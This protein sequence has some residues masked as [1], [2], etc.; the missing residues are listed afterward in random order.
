M[1]GTIS[2]KRWQAVVM[3]IYVAVSYIYI[4]VS[5]SSSF[6]FQDVDVCVSDFFCFFYDVKYNIF[7]IYE[8]TFYCI[9]TIYL[10]KRKMLVNHI[11]QY[12]STSRLWHKIVLMVFKTALLICTI[13]LLILI[14]VASLKNSTYL[15]N[16][17]DENSFARKMVMDGN[18]IVIDT[19]TVIV[20][21]VVLDFLRL[22]A[23]GVVIAILY[24]TTRKSIVCF[25]CV[26]IDIILCITGKNGI[27]YN[28]ILN[29]RLVYLG[30]I[31]L[32]EKVW[33]AVLFNVLLYIF[34]VICFKRYRKDML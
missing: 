10:I 15:C 3:G 4:I 28:S 2:A 20:T 32:F 25:L 13:N 6:F 34:G 23:T 33:N 14:I 16:W 27:Y 17:S 24:W 30:I 21:Y 8:L 26:F 7:L 5:V 11:V 31:D 22:V 9:M 1:N 29:Q 12:K 19:I 18:V